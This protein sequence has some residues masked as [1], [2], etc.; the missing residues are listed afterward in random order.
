MQ[1]SIFNKL[2]STLSVLIIMSAISLKVQ[3]ADF[4]I[5]L[6]IKNHKFQPAELKAPAKQR[7]KL[8]IHNQDEGAEEFESKS[9]K[10]EKIIPGGTKA[11]IYIGPLQPGKYTFM[12]EFHQATAQG[13]IVVE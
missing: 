13:V 6:N 7:I 10:R 9:L 8:I 2:L 5:K 4:E 11:T 1:V 12:G 3:A